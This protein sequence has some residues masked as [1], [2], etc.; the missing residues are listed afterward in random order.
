MIY[1]K[2]QTIVLLLLV[3]PILL[4]SGCQSVKINPESFDPDLIKA[5]KLVNFHA[6]KYKDEKAT[7]TLKNGVRTIE[8][9]A[10]QFF[11]EPTTIIMNKGEKIKLIITAED[12]PH[13]F[14]IEGFQIPD[15]DIDTVIRKGTPL[16]LEFEADQVGVWQ[17]ICTIYC[18]FGHSTMKG[19][20]VIR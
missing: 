13:G 6:E 11:F 4:L 9:K 8:I 17:F 2:I 3:V 18:G 10:Y 12:I 16:I 5:K 7:G 14:E 19:T 15:Y 1:K 20:F